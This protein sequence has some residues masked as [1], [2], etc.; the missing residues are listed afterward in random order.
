LL[1]VI[2]IIAV[3]I[4]MLFPAVQKTRDAAARIR[5]ANNLHQISLAAQQYHTAMG[6]FPA[7]VRWQ[8]GR[9]PQLF[10]SWLAQLL[11]YLDQQNLWALTQDAYAKSRS[12]FSNPPHV[13]LSTPVAVFA[14][15]SDLRA[16]QVHIAGRSG[17]PVAF[18]SYLGVAGKDVLTHDGVLYRDSSIRIADITDGTSNTLFAGERPPSKDFQYGWWYAGYGQ[19]LTGSADMLLGVE[20]P[21]LLPVTK[22]SC[23]PGTYRF[24]PGR[25]DN[26]CDM[27][28][29]WSPHSS[30]ANFLFVD[31]SVRFL[32]YKVAPLLPALAS[33]EG[34][35]VVS[36]TD[37]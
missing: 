18:T 17:F 13:G 16:L 30:G 27:F 23:P 2:A 35:E 21:N 3:L 7:G 14:C 5:C 29:F 37:F 9:D 33:R 25:F 19:R 1:V 4:G 8:K 36:V 11:P 6:S 24:A 22:G 28:H 10:S 12:P 15:P 31:G 20:E 32:S 26:Q 34:G